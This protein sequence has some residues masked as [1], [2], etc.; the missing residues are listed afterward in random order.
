MLR[1]MSISAEEVQRHVRD[2]PDWPAP[3]ITFRDLT[4]LIGDAAAFGAV[5]D[6]FVEHFRETR[7]DRVLG[8]EAR[9]FLFAAPIA[10]ALGVGMV[11]VRKSGK[12]PHTTEQQGYTLKYGTDLLEIHSDAVHH[13]EAILIVDDVIA[14]GGTAAATVA[15]VERLG[16]HVAGLAFVVELVALGGRARLA[17]HDFV[18]LATY[19]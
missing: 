15:L 11:P 8:I 12:L 16:G 19:D 13:G 1:R 14:T 9:G 18:A 5:I 3:G 2:V 10:H 17:P 4:P 7:V 6:A